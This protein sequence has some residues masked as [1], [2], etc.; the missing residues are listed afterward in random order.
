MCCLFSWIWLT[1]CMIYNLE[2]YN[3]D[4]S[5][6]ANSHFDHM[7]QPLA[8][9]SNT[10]CKRCGFYKEDILKSDEFDEWEFCPSDFTNPDGSYNK[11][12]VK[13]FNA[14]F[15]CPDC[16]PLGRGEYFCNIVYVGMFH[17]VQSFTFGGWLGELMVQQRKS[18][19]ITNVLT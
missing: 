12:K 9:F 18:E 17:L 11:F 7:L 19:S 15:S 13:E 6:E 14:A 3:G 8:E 5:K 10:K 16:V 1:N 2:V 4:S